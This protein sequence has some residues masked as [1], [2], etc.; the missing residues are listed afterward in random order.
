MI[1]FQNQCDLGKVKFRPH[2]IFCHR[3]CAVPIVI[4]YKIESTS[5]ADSNK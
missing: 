3:A 1:C 2:H 4:C 5:L